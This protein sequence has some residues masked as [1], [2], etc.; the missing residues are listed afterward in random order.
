MCIDP[1]WEVG[2]RGGRGQG[3]A[4]VPPC[5]GDPAML[6]HSLCPSAREFFMQPFLG[7]QFKHPDW[8]LR[9]LLQAKMKV[10]VSVTHVPAN[11]TCPHIPILF[12]LTQLHTKEQVER[13][14]GSPKSWAFL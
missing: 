9:L 8:A 3:D 5:H 6:H 1:G 7:A 11:T 4:Q 12:F 10:L 13:V 14:V 2:V